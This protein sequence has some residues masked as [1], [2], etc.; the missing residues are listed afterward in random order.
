LFTGFSSIAIRERHRG[1]DEPKAK[2]PWSVSLSELASFNKY[3]IFVA[4]WGLFPIPEMVCACPGTSP[5]LLLHR[6]T[7]PYE[8]SVRGEADD[9]L[10]RYQ[11]PLREYLRLA[12]DP[13][14]FSGSFRNILPLQGMDNAFL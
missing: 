3:P 8:S 7:N 4:R 5:A 12:E 14:S 2:F 9:Y 6:L 11:Y 1:R 10:I 13:F